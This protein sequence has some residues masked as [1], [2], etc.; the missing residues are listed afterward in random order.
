[1]DGVKNVSVSAAVIALFIFIITMYRPPGMFSYNW[2]STIIK[3]ELFT[4]DVE[5]KNQFITHGKWKSGKKHDQRCEFLE[6][7][8]CCK[9]KQ[10]QHFEFFDKKLNLV[11]AAGEFKR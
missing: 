4:E 8:K 2:N 10:D 7:N 5:V 1:M 11:N 9:T 3:G 6:I